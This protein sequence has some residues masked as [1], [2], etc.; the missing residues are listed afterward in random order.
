MRSFCLI[1]AVGVAASFAGCEAYVRT[2]NPPP[3]K[4]VVKPAPAPAHVDVNV[5]RN[6][7]GGVNVDVHK[8]P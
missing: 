3:T 6:P 7:G 8:T 5:N 2:E 1:S 4:V